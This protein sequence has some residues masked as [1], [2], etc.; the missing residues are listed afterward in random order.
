M[1]GPNIYMKRN[2]IEKRRETGW[3]RE[4]RKKKIKLERNGLELENKEK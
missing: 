1:A 2:E 3:A 4:Q